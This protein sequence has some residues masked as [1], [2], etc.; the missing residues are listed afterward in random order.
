MPTRNPISA[1]THVQV[2]EMV[3]RMTCTTGIC[4]AFTLES[5]H[6]LQ[7]RC[8][9][10][11]AR[12]GGGDDSELDCAT[13]ADYCGFVP[14]HGNY[15][16]RLAPILLVSENFGHIP[17]NF[18]RWGC[19][20]SHSFM[21]S[22]SSFLVFSFSFSSERILIC[23]SGLGWTSVILMILQQYQK[24]LSISGKFHETGAMWIFNAD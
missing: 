7:V 12:I 21:C 8:F 19:R 22:R 20:E 1:W 13:N 16:I 18:G 24:S 23:I 9:N 5:L 3:Q 11:N 17:L 2:C 14:S 4:A 15:D 6:W 10:V